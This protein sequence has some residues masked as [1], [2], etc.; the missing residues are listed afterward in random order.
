[1]NTFQYDAGA[2]LGHVSEVAQ[3]EPG[4]E[5]DSTSLQGPENSCATTLPIQ[6]DRACE[7][8][9]G[10][11]GETPQIQVCQACSTIPKKTRGC[12]RCQKVLQQSTE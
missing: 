10:R 8:L 3:P 6:P 12:N 2:A 11:R 5:P 7:D 4:L 1:M 9:Q